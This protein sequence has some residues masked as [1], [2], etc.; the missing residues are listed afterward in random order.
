MHKDCFPSAAALVNSSTFMDDF[1]AGAQDSNGAI[2]ICYQFTA[3]M[4]K[5]ILPMG[6][7]ASNSE[8][9]RNI[10]RVSGLENVSTIQVLGLSCDTVRDTIF[11]DHRDP[12]DNAQ[13]TPTTKR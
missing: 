12:T 9:L 7:W 10:W 2:T 6:K 5:I 1:A 11:A 13:E 3:L 4:R 8:P